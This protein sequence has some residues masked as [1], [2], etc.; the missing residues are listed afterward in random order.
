MSPPFELFIVNIFTIKEG[1]QDLLGRAWLRSAQLKRKLG[2]ELNDLD[3]WLITENA[4]GGTWPG[5]EIMIYVF[6]SPRNNVTGTLIMGDVWYAEQFPNCLPEDVG[7]SLKVPPKEI[8]HLLAQSQ[9]ALHRI[10]LTEHTQAL[11]YWEVSS[12]LA[13]SPAIAGTNNICF[14][15][16]P[17]GTDTPAT[18]AQVIRSIVSLLKNDE[19]KCHW[20]RHP[21]VVPTKT[22]NE[23]NTAEEGHKLP[24]LLHFQPLRYAY[25]TLLIGKMR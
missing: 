6:E 3:F 7:V 23:R 14:E 1:Y 13:Y 8:G 19:I 21:A 17:G 2:H 10:D 16:K 9:K 25:V 15:Q 18:I 22:Y 20:R 4:Q 11:T 12:K 24:A 5:Y